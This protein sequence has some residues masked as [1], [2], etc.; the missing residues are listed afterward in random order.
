MNN[1]TRKLINQTTEE[2]CHHSHFHIDLITSHAKWQILPDNYFHQ[3]DNWDWGWDTFKP[4]ATLTKTSTPTRSQ[5]KIHPPGGKII[6]NNIKTKTFIK[7]D[8]LRQGK[9]D[10][11][12]VNVLDMFRWKLQ[13]N[14][15][16][17]AVHGERASHEATGGIARYEGVNLYKTNATLSSVYRVI[18][19]MSYSLMLT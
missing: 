7:N 5:F 1:L 8:N 14:S 19:L 2:M 18:L 6:K 9:P 13:G 12:G 10:A 15:Y 11:C 4:R 16:M 3:K 17:H